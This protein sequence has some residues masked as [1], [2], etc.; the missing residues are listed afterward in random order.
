MKL[1]S[2][3]PKIIMNAVAISGGEVANKASTF[4]VYA[5]VSRAIGL[6]SFGQFALGMTL[7]YTCHVFGVAGLPTTL[8]RMVAKRP[9]FAKSLLRLGYLAGL[10]A[11]LLAAG[12]MIGLAVLM[13][14][15]WVTTQ[16]IMIMALAVPFYSL[17]MVTEAVIKGREKMHLIALGNIPGNLQL[18]LGSWYLL[19]QDGS[20]LHL[21]WNV[22]V[23]RALTAVCLHWLAVR[24]MP[25]E[26]TYGP[27]RLSL[28]WRLIVRSR[29]FLWSDSVAAI[30]ASLFPLILSKFATEREVGMLNA[31]F[32]LL[33]PV[34]ILYRSL[35]HSS[36]PAL[37]I[38][39]K[40]GREHV[41][42]LSHSI[43]SFIIR[44][45]YPAALVMFVMASEF[46]TLVYG[47]KGFQEGA[48]VLQILAFGLLCD[49]LNPILGHGLWAVGAD[50]AVFRIVIVN[51]VI[52][53]A[54]GLILIGTWGLWGAA[55]CVLIGSFA[56]TLMHYFVFT[57]RVGETNLGYDFL[58]LLPA[59][60]FSAAVIVA[61]IWPPIISLSAALVIYGVFV[62]LFYNQN[63]VGQPS[64]RRLQP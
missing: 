41:A 15:Q 28:A 25:N 61:A 46:L 60:F 3:L 29:V 55:L 10:L 13:Q 53:L 38:A 56:N 9:A 24:A 11:S 47:N 48:Y 40:Q 64:I 26:R 7:L 8:T 50:R 36:F 12:F 57:I 33:Q 21:A 45:A 54:L 43:L 17:T 35:G 52:T 32:Q 58:R 14:Y 44:L 23:A 5:A 59:I 2:R 1:P 20:V 27:F 16:V 30:G 4:L 6:E 51:I 19:W 18:V 34:Q 42:D 63:S 31:A 62:W 22:V 37:V 39:A 49:P